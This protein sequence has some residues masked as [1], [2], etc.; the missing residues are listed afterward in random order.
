[1][2]KVCRKIILVCLLLVTAGAAWGQRV[3]QTINDGWK[4]SPIRLIKRC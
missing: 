3:T 2:C 4:F 1:M